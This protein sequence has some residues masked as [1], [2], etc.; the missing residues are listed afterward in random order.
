MGCASWQSHCHW[1][2]TIS[3]CLLW[4]PSDRR[5]IYTLFSRSLIFSSLSLSHH[6]QWSSKSVTV[7]EVTSP[8]EVSLPGSAPGNRS[9]CHWS[10]LT[11][12]WSIF[13]RDLMSSS[14]SAEDFL[15]APL[16][17]N[18]QWLDPLVFE[19]LVWSLS[20]LDIVLW[21]GQPFVDSESAR[22]EA[23]LGTPIFC[24]I[25]VR[26]LHRADAQILTSFEA[27]SV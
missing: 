22:W 15:V 23:L 20:F 14:I 19:D 12:I 2:P 18:I 9:Y 21:M 24:Y 1:S 8:G 25:A 26:D 13:H 5:R 11:L 16:Y 27:L 4:K 7:S 17:F 6:C 3:I 10:I